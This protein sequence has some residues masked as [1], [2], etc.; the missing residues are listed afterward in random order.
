MQMNYT[1]EK[2][3]KKLKPH[4]VVICKISPVKDDCYGRNSK[5][6]ATTKFNEQLKMVSRQHNWS[7]KSACKDSKLFNWRCIMR[8]TYMD[9][10]PGQYNMKWENYVFQ[11]KSNERTKTA[12][13]TIFSTRR[14]LK[15]TQ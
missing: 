2:S 10:I 7:T 6:E 14:L 15:R 11:E 4:R 8:I 13:N 12:G 3:M 9:M 5:N 1:V